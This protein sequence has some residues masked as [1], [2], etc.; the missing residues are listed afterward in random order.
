MQHD[1]YHCSLA[2]TVAPVFLRNIY[3]NLKM[4]ERYDYALT[5]PDYLARTWQQHKPAL[6]NRNA[7]GVEDQ[8]WVAHFCIAAALGM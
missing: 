5:T 2:P 6:I 7:V 8:G 3:L 4:L 1:S